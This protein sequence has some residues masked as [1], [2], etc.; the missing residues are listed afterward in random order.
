[1]KEDSIKPVFLI[2]GNI[3]ILGQIL[4]K[5]LTVQCGMSRDSDSDQLGNSSNHHMKVV[6]TKNVSYFCQNVPAVAHSLPGEDHWYKQRFLRK[7][8]IIARGSFFPLM[9]HLASEVWLV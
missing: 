1:M 8:V 2:P 4:C 5:G 3:D 7:E 6:K 9:F